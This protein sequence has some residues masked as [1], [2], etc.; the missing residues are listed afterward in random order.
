MLL[1]TLSFFLLIQRDYVRY[2]FISLL[3]L[4]LIFT[5][6]GLFAGLL[7]P[8]LIAVEAFHNFRSKKSRLGWCGIG[9]LLSIAIYWA[10]F[11][12]N[13]HYNPA[14]PEY[15]FPHEKPLEYLFFVASMLS[16]FYGLAGHGTFSISIGVAIAILLA[17]IIGLHGTHVLRR[18][19]T[20]RRSSVIFCL[21]AFT[22]IYCIET[23]IG[24]VCLGWDGA[25]RASRYVTL[26][27]PG[28]LAI[29]L[30]LATI[31]QTWVRTWCCASYGL[32]LIWGTLF[33]STEDKR[34]VSNWHDGL[35][36]WKQAYLATH[37]EQISNKVSA[38]SIYPGAI[39][40]NHLQYLEKNNLNLFKSANK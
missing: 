2:L 7:S 19:D 9:V 35:K 25:S 20:A 17:V 40:E 10:L 1:F 21:A 23:A 36:A 38:F 12:Y 31:Q 11:L 29:G 16:N 6:F 27:I 18:A 3:T 28:G 14:T 30:H 33:L 37:D 32:V 15:R 5:G 8:L 26:M 22:L 39:P 13:Y 34:T 24:R 4:G